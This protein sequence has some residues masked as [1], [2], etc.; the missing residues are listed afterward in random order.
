[1]VWYYSTGPTGWDAPFSFSQGNP[2]G[3]SSYNFTHIFFN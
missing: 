1:M 3:S 2:D